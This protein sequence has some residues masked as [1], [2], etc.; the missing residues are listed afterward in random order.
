[1]E[2]AA[3]IIKA[4]GKQTRVWVPIRHAHWV[5]LVDPDDWPDLSHVEPSTAQQPVAT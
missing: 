4:I 1:M 5:M 2:D 3:Y